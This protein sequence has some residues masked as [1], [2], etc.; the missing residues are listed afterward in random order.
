MV[1]F[2]S[3]YL[4]HIEAQQA[5]LSEGGF[6]LSDIPNYIPGVF[7][8]PET[9]HNIDYLDVYRRVWGREI[10]GNGIGKLREVAL[11]EIT[12]NEYNP[13]FEEDPAF[14]HKW[15]EPYDTLDVKLMQEQSAMYQEILEANGVIVHRIEFP[16]PPVGAFGPMMY[17]WAARELLVLN[18][19]S[20]IPKLGFS[21]LSFGRPE[22]LAWWAFTRLGIPPILTITGKGVCEAGPCFFLA[23]DVFVAALSVAFNQ[24]GL[25]QLLPVVKRSTGLDEVHNLVI[26][27]ATRD[28][29][30]PGSG[31][32]A[33][34][35][36]IIG[37]LD[38]DKV[39]LYPGGIDFETLSWLVRHGYKIAEIERDEQVQYAPA[40]VTLLEPGHVIMHAGADKAIA[41]VRKLGVE[42]E[43]LP[44]GEFLK[45]GGG[46]HCSTMEILKDPGP[47]LGDP[48]AVKA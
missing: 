39:L 41:A 37:P 35:D 6:K 43:V 11:T 8:E 30:D 21:A 17:M 29:F 4:R 47:A 15:E 3:Q 14:F 32:S 5:K 16:D 22:Y 23:E 33:H 7:P 46:V 24:E 10:R 34:P 18:G 48:P 9:W 44:Y 2:D 13:I 26:K 45:A 38:T 27:T 28:Y 31:A 42:V 19:G 40:N 25:D 12:S 20:V 36:M 1:E